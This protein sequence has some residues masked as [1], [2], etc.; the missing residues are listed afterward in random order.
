V[1]RW[2]LRDMQTHEWH[3][4]TYQAFICAW[5]ATPQHAGNGNELPANKF[6]RNVDCFSEA[7]AP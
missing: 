3:D 5:A 4:T 2:A 6:A 7:E 1:R